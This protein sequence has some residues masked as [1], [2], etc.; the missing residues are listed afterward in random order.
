MQLA[1]TTIDSSLSSMT[2]TSLARI[3]QHFDWSLSRLTEVAI[4]ALT[5]NRFSSSRMKSSNGK[6]SLPSH[7]NDWPNAQGVRCFLLLPVKAEHL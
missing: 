4:P 2:F 1:N 6:V 5:V 3:Y 7:Y